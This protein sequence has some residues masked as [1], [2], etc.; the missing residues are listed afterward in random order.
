MLYTNMLIK[1]NSER[2]PSFQICGPHGKLHGVRG[3]SKNYDI[4]FGKK[5]GH[6][7]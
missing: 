3:L 1:K 4:Q 6:G 7:L 5:L 2:F